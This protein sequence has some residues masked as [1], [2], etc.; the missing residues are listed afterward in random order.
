MALA[1][2]QHNVLVFLGELFQQLKLLYLLVLDLFKS[3]LF[4]LFVVLVAGAF[5]T[6]NSGFSH[7]AVVGVEVQEC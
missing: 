1:Q 5:Q 4:L 3:K 7:K 2:S 6:F